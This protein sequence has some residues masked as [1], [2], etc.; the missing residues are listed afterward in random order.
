MK[1]KNKNR[2][3]N[4]NEM[5]IEMK[6]KIKTVGEG[7]IGTVTRFHNEKRARWRRKYQKKQRKHHWG[8]EYF[9]RKIMKNTKI[10]K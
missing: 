10:L 8:E 6:I 3:R 5:E 2:Y 4:K 9:Y 7:N 1:S